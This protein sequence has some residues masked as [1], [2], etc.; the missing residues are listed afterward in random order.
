M[1]G[2]VRLI[3]GDVG[4][5]IFGLAAFHMCRILL[6]LAPRTIVVANAH[7]ATSASTAIFVPDRAAKSRAI[8]VRCHVDLTSPPDNG[9][10][11]NVPD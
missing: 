5:M 4:S 2:K 6:W 8:F 3:A 7:I 1:G 11:S 9:E 10:P